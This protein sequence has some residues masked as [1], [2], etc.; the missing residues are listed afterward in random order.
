MKEAIRINGQI[1]KRIKYADVGDLCEGATC[2][3][4]DCGA[5]P[6][7]YHDLGCDGERCP[8]CG[9]QLISCDC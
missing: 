2:N 3:C 6:K 1:Y 9:G 8:V 7:E 5:M 4:D